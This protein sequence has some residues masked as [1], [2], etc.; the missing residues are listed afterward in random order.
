MTSL[1][2][3]YRC[4]SARL[5]ER[6]VCSKLAHKAYEPP[7]KTIEVESME[8][9]WGLF[10]LKG[11]WHNPVDPQNKKAGIVVLDGK[12]VSYLTSLSVKRFFML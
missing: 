6:A 5:Q 2:K 8:D 4:F 3:F 11:S 7:W 10:A 9:W 1:K 12:I